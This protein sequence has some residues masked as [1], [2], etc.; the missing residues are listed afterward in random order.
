MIAEFAPAKINLYLHVGPLRRDRLH[1][2]RSLFAFVGDGDRI[3]AAAA[4]D[5]SLKLEGPFAAMLAREDVR[6]NLV[7]RAAMALRQ[8]AGVRDGAAMVLEKNLPIA[9]GIGGGSADAAAALRALVR[10]WNLEISPADLRRIAFRLGADVPA[11]L[12]AAPVFVG[13]AGETISAGPRLAPLHATLVNPRVVMPTGPIFRAFDAQNRAPA[14][15]AFDIAR[16]AT[17]SGAL[18]MLDA[19]RNDLEPHAIRRAPVVGDVVRFLKA[20]PGA[21]GAR[22][23]GS[24]ATVFALYASA[25][26]AE[27]AARASRA[28]GWWATSAPILRGSS[29]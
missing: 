20:S 24:G 11:C 6:R 16:P 7:C 12:D 10:L 17:I 23:S 28:R 15:P 5:I 22:M 3:L 2:L 9:S 13:G 21:L 1:D 14:A 18:Q 27:R 26:A 19:T 25:T 29:S 4:P 8:Y